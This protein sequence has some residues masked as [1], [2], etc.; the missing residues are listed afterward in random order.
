[1]NNSPTPNGLIE[2]FEEILGNNS[3]AGDEIKG[4]D[5]SFERGDFV[6]ALA[7]YQA[8]LAILSGADQRAWWDVTDNDRSEAFSKIGLSLLAL[9]ECTLAMESFDNSIRVLESTYQQT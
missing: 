2:F 5:K 7:H 3:R 1:M 6:A 4:G 9:G 8:A